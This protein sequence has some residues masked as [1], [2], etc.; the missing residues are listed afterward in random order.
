MGLGPKEKPEFESQMCSVPP[1][2]YILKGK[3]KEEF[4]SFFDQLIRC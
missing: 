3:K 4:S 1:L 2:K